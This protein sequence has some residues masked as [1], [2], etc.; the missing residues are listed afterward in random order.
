[1][2][3]YH[4]GQADFELLT[5]GDLPAWPPEVLGLQAWSHLL[6]P[7]L[8]CNG[9][10]LARSNLF[11]PGSNSCSVTRLECSG[12]I[13][14][15]F[16]FHLLGSS[17]SPASA[18]GVAWIRVEQERTKV[19]SPKEES[20]VLSFFILTL[21][22]GLV[23][24]GAIMAHSLQSQLLRLKKASHLSLPSSWD[25]RSIHHS[26]L[27]FV[28]YVEMDS[29]C[30]VQAGLK[31]LGSSNLSALAFQSAMITGKEFDDGCCGRY[32]KST[33]K[34]V[35][36]FSETACSLALLPRPECTGVISA[37]CNLRLLGSSDFLASAS[38]VAGIKDAC[39][40]TQLI[41]VFLIE[42]GFY[43]VGQ[44]GLELLT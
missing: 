13:S 34:I 21:S 27:I 11:L 39:H 17:D 1:M 20:F 40:H 9:V 26:E 38:Q 37:H 30:V 14:A 25:Y 31:L 18:S 19:D 5:S 7:R 23:D 6:S 15:H 32:G 22:P 29:H 42:M 10:I 36:S 8:K 12:A 2:E 16:N 28:Y 41:C 44:A 24:T 35:A 33:C 43:H 4:V 3:F